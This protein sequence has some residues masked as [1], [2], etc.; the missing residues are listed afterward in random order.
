MSADGYGW[1]RM[2][3]VVSEA[4]GDRKTRQT[5]AQMVARRTCLI[6]YGRGNFPKKY[7]R[8]GIEGVRMGVAVAAAVEK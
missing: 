7:V 1:I 5:E 8:T 3:A 6:R 4:R 2:G